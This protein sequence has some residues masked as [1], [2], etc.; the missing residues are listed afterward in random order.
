MSFVYS[1]TGD[2]VQRYKYNSKELE[3]L[4]ALDWYDYGARWYD[5]VLARWH[6]VDPLAEKYPDISPYVYCNNNAVNA[7]APDGMDWYLDWDKTWQFSPDVHSQKDLK[8]GQLYKACSFFTG[9][10]SNLVHY[11]NDGSILFS[12]ETSAYRRMW[13]Q[14]DVHY[15]NNGDKGGRE[16]GA[17]ILNNGK[18]LVLPDYKNDR[19]TSHLSE[20]GYNISKDGVITK[21]NDR[22]KIVGQI[23]THQDKFYDAY[24]SY[25]TGEGYGDLGISKQ[26]GGL[27][28]IVIGHDHKIHGIY[29]GKVKGNGK[30]TNIGSRKD[31]LDGKTLLFQWLKIY[32]TK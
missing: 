20:Y 1:A 31:L 15:R 5:P 28:V 8:S 32:P 16:V 4:L 3:R 14:A 7:V 13:S 11:R 10:G 30:I 6:A 17:F 18:V 24:P 27:P 12:N 23:H 25:Y 19:N 26:M 22:I 2:D 9:R 21:G 29:S